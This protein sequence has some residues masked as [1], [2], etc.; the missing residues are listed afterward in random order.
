[1]TNVT[2]RKGND[3]DT[4]S[5]SNYRQRKEGTQAFASQNTIIGDVEYHEESDKSKLPLFKLP[6]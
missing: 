1:M 2:D 3:L 5:L 4:G 6:K